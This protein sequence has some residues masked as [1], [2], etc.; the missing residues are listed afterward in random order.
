MRWV[1]WPIQLS[2]PGAYQTYTVWVVGGLVLLA[3]ASPWLMD[4][5]LALIELLMGREKRDQVEAGLV[6]P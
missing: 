4:F 2:L 3:L 5:A 6:R 1:R